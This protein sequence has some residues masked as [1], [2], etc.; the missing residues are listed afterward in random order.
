MPYIKKTLITTEACDAVHDKRLSISLTADG[1]SFSELSAQGDLL[2]F[3]EAVGGH[4]VSMTDA[5]RDIKTF[6][7]QVGV[8]PLGFRSME[9]MVLS[10]ENVWVPDEVF[11]P[12]AVRQYLK[13]V[14]GEGRQVMTA[15]CRQLASTAVFSADEGLA[16]AFKVALPSL[17]VINQHVKMASIPALGASHPVLLSH[18]RSVANEGRVDL[19]AF[20]DGRYV[21]GNTVCFTD[22]SALRFQMLEVVRTFGLERPDTELLMCGDVDRERFSRFRPYFPKT[23]LYTGRCRAGAEFRQL[24]T[25]RHA[26]ILL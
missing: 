12:T 24:H 18:W 11:T 5:T 20:V 10:D 16:T 14:G 7:A 19:A 6:F 1:F 21:Y 13:V 17:K 4:A 2:A 3:G 9:L 25:Y 15:P 23:T 22:E 8:K 26:L